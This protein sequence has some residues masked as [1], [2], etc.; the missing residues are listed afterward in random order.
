MGNIAI[1][2]LTG[3]YA[4]FLV[5]KQ[6]CALP[7]QEVVE[8]IRIQPITEVIG[9]RDYLTGVINLRGNIIPVL[10]L[11]MRYNMPTIDFN[12]KSRI[13][14][15]RNNN[16]DIGLIVD[17]VLMVA[18]MDGGQLEPPLE[19]FNSIEKDCFKGFAKVKEQLVGILNLDKVL[20]PDEVEDPVEKEG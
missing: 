1:E 6:Y 4:V 11:R 10:S 18:D 17:E 8:I 12:K 16:E 9:E 20:Y 2:Q 15:V 5:E 3:Q 7:I 19:M 13:I 14:I